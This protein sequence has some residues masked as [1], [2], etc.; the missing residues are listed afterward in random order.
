[1]KGLISKFFLVAAASIAGFLAPAAIAQV[2]ASISV[3]K[4][5]A[6]DPVVAGNQLTYTI[7]VNNEGPANAANTLVADT[8]PAG[9]TFVSLS[10]PVGWSC[11]TPSLGSGG[12]V[13]CS[14]AS[15]SVGSETF[16]LV[17]LVD[18]SLAQGSVIVNSASITST[19]ADTDPNDNL[20]S[21]TT[22]VET[23]ADLFL[24]KMSAPN[25]VLVGNTITYAIS[26]S[27]T[28]PSYASNVSWSDTLPA[29][30]SFAS[31][32]VA[33]G[34]SCTTPAVGAVGTVTCLRASLPIG[35]ANFVLMVTTAGVAPGSVISNAA[36]VA[37]DTPDPNPSNNSA[38]ATTNAVSPSG[39][40]ATKTV[41]GAFVPG[42]NIVYTITITNAGPG[43]QS[44]N[45]GDEFFDQLPAAVTLL[46]ATA[47]TGTV[48]SNLGANNV[49]WNGGLGSGNSVTI[50][51][52]ATISA[53]ALHAQQIFNQ[54][55][56]NFDGDGDGSNESSS[57]T[58]NP[59][60][61]GS[62][63]ATGFAVLGAVSAVPVLSARSYWLLCVLVF[64]CAVLGLRMQGARR[65]GSEKALER[66]P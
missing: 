7:T 60:L 26:V 29:G 52:S 38:N 15:F 1:M 12:T 61:P 13:S 20:A 28:G 2:T 25:P 59:G 24:T 30:T 43:A 31:L 10:P 56:V 66:K 32:T 46:G 18:A 11:T 35:S 53:S 22:A 33:A 57:L 9:T 41:A 6:P 23:S 45:A 37:S 49:S 36:S 58:D 48:S 51:I 63:D 65:L 8:L 17:V 21:A 16:T 14:N 50:T 27:N 39:L 62:Q 34:W 4:I 40:S 19:T 44:N 64:F 55:V 54:G 42:G 47:S 5:D 3:V